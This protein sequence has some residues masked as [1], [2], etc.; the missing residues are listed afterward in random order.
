MESIKHIMKIFEENK[1]IRVNMTH[2]TFLMKMHLQGYNFCME[3]MNKRHLYKFFCK[4][5]EIR[6]LT[7]NQI[8]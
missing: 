8:N 2:Y 5:I 1:E 4:P 3:L 6:G 7:I